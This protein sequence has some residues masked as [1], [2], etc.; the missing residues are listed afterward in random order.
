MEETNN[1]R[2]NEENFLYL[3]EFRTY[4][5]N[6]RKSN[7]TPLARKTINRHVDNVLDFLYYSSTHNYNVDDDGP[8]E[9]PVDETLLRRGR[10]Y[11]SPYLNG[12]LSYSNYCSED[13]IRQSIG[14]IGKFY[15]FLKET[16]RIEKE[17]ADEVIEELKDLRFDL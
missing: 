9:V 11:L 4:L 17:I 2:L 1:S 15:N 13:T 12:W 5:E 8:D 14:S 3:P 6:Y 16:G 7:G 10:E